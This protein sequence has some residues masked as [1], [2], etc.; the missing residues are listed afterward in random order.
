M[1]TLT[2]LNDKIMSQNALNAFVEFLAPLSLFSK[3]YSAEAT[4]KGSAII[5]PLFSN[6]SATT[7]NQNYEIGGGTASGVTVTLNIHKHVPLSL[8]DQQ[9]ADSSV[10]DLEKWG[11]QAGA[12]LAT[13]IVTDIFSLVTSV[14]FGTPAITTTSGNW[15]YAQTNKLRR[16]ANV[17]K[18]PQ[19]GRTLFLDPTAMEA[20][21]NDSALKS[22]YAIELAQTVATGKVTR[23]AG[24]NLYE[25]N[26]IPTTDVQYAFGCIPDAIAL[27]VRYLEP[28]NPGKYDSVMRMTDDA[29]GLTIGYRR[30]YQEA[31]GTVHANFECLW[32]RSVGLSTGLLRVSSP[33]T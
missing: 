24:W 17:A 2:N 29:T 18:V 30:H 3:S 4:R 20:L 5:V 26:L 6:L 19:A 31:T 16:L 32:G 9:I 1:A 22:S 25:S 12:A 8:T 27:A 7:F 33:G 11:Y 14:N 23:V 21:L 13:A 15:S 28:I 10:A